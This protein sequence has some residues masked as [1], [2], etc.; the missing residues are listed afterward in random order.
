MIEFECIVIHLKNKLTLKFITVEVNY[1]I[2]GVEESR[3]PF[4]IKSYFII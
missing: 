2:F 3:F 1:Q 4:P